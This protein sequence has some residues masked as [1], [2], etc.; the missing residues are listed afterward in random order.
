MAD[1]TF[2]P[3]C[4][5]VVVVSYCS[6]DTL[7][8]CVAPLAGAPGVNVIVVD[9]ASPD[10]AVDTVAD[11]AGLDVV[12]A[13][14]NGGFSSGCNAGAAAGSAPYVLLLNPDAVLQPEALGKLVAVLESDDL[15]GLVSPKLLG[16]DG[17]VALSQRRFPRLRSSFAQAL[18]LH[19]LLPSL[20]EI[21]R[22]PAAYEGTG[23]PDWVSGA[24][25][26]IRRSALDEIGGMDED[27]FLYC[28]DT[29]VCMRLRE[30]GYA[31]RFEPSVRA[32]HIGGASG[33][34]SRLRPVLA[35]SRVTYARKH[36]RWPA[37][38]IEAFAVALGEGVH[39]AVKLRR[40]EQVRGHLAA[41][42]A[43]VLGGRT[44]LPAA[45]TT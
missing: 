9:N 31:I 40:P 42:R 26:L 3:A 41:L 2:A 45:R 29:D 35:C 22:E 6:R 7:R 4:V 39:A 33:S 38:L 14:R 20:D 23:S 10:D 8:G 15:I 25:M 19:R 11:L 24:C 13:G 17:E 27:F 37:P 1:E 16:P 34:R 43:V 21:V 5:D 36:F 28:E 18:F 12:R 30:A 44:A 32:D